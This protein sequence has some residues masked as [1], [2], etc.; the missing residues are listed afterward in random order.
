MYAVFSTGGRQ[1][2]AVPGDREEAIKTLAAEHKTVGW[3][4]RIVGFLMMWIGLMMF[5]GPINAVLDVI[6]FL[7]SAGRVLIGIAMFPISLVLTLLTVILSIIFH[8][9]ILLTLFLV[10]MGAGGYFLYRRKK[11][12]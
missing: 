9:P 12:G 1:Y 5:F 2:R 3:V 4:L 8:N 6:P 11:Y 10:G 7:G